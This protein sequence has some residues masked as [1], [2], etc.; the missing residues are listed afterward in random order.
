[1][2][3]VRRLTCA[4]PGF[5]PPYEGFEVGCRQE[6]QEGVSRWLRR[7][8]SGAPNAMTMCE[9]GHKEGCCMHPARTVLMGTR[10][11]LRRDT[12]SLGGMTVC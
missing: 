9:P 2:G 6:Q 7:H 11:L 1:V 8:V 10:N 5:K 4:R 3:G 12:M